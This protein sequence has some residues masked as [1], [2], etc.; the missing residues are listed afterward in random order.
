MRLN[1]FES[2]LERLARTLT[3]QFGVQV[4]CQGEE[5]WTDGRQI[6]LPSLPE[7]MDPPLERMIV[8]YLDHE[9]A[10]VAFSDFQV[11][12]EFSEKHP[13]Y[14]ALLNVVEDGLIERRAMQAGRSCEL[15]RHVR[16]G[17]GSSGIP[18]CKA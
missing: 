5:A 6:V 9:L 8:G 13:G 3:E 11:V 10:H 14:E 16:A 12:K 1:P 2:E 15:G 4:I 18:C 7:P 17:S